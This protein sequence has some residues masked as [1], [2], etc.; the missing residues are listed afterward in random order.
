MRLSGKTTL[1]CRKRVEILDNGSKGRVGL[2]FESSV[3]SFHPISVLKNI[4]KN[5]KSIR[6]YAANSF[7]NKRNSFFLFMEP[8]LKGFR[9]VHLGDTDRANSQRILKSEIPHN[10]PNTFFSPSNNYANEIIP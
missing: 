10:Y 7:S 5:S 9:S 4:F 6:F 2:K 1:S 3:L 8:F